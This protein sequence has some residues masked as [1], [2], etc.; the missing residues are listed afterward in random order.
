MARALQATH[1][2]FYLRKFIDIQEYRVR[3]GCGFQALR[4]IKGSFEFQSVCG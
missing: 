4:G 2:Y 3:E 1:K